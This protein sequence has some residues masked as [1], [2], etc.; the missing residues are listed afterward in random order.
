[1]KLTTLYANL[2][3]NNKK[4]RECS[5]SMERKS[6]GKVNKAINNVCG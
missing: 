3:N 4:S 6:Q 2:N 5:R 1:M